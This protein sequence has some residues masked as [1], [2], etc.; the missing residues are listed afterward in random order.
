[1]LILETQHLSIGALRGEAGVRVSS[2]DTSKEIYGKVLVT[3]VSL[4]SGLFS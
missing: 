1:M 4:H 2:L 3:D